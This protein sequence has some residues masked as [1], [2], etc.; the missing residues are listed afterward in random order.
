MRVPAKT[1]VSLA[2][3]A[4]AVAAAT[5]H[6]VIDVVGDFA[7]SHDSYDHLRHGSREI[8]SAVALALGTMLAIR[9]LRACCEIAARNRARVGS[10]HF[11]FIETAGFFAGVVLFTALLVPS[12]EILDATAAGLA[13]G[14]LGD[15][16]GGSLPIGITSAVSCALL[17]GASLYGLARWLISHRDSI[18]VIVE[19]LLRRISN[20]PCVNSNFVAR[21]A[22]VMPRR[23]TPHAPHLAKRGPPQFRFA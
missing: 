11:G 19:T 5:A 7:L 14:G 10:I 9:G 6:F 12:M 21:G 15:A 4:A 13:F 22:S 20:A 23:R 3:C 16:F 1:L 18:V 17:A 2:L 8:V